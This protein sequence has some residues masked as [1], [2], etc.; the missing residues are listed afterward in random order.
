MRWQPQSKPHR[1]PTALKDS[2]PLRL[3]LIL[4]LMFGC[5]ALALAENT[6]ELSDEFLEY[7]GNMETGDDNWTDFAATVDNAHAPTG[8][9]TPKA[10]SHGAQTS[11]SQSSIATAHPAPKAHQ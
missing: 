6:A 7:L 1:V 8:D 10:G 4:G 11:S 9:S 5:A 3:K 2:A